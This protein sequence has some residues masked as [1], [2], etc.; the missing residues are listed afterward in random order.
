MTRV[1][2]VGNATLDVVNRVERYPVED[3]EVRAL[4]HTQR[5]GGNA[6]NTAIVLARL[7]ASSHWVGNLADPA[8][9]MER[10]FERLGV[11]ISRA[12]RIAGAR[13]PTSY[14]LV[15]A[16]TGSRSIVHYRDMPEYRADD[17]VQLDLDGFDWVHFEGRAVDQLGRMLS[18]A[19]STQGLP[20]S[21]E[22]E[23]PRPGIEALFGQADLLLFSRDYAEARGFDEA[24][25]LLA[26]LP[27]GR[28]ASC[29]WGDAGAWSIDADGR[30]GH[31]PAP[32]L[33]TVVDTLGAGDVFNAALIHALASRVP[34]ERALEGAVETASAKCLHE[35]L[36]VNL[37]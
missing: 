17:F 2:C 13:P 3:S 8:V 27:R 28:R 16:A 6:A 33:A 20:I 35:G 4:A 21:L 18:R 14:V 15:S 26:S 25:A 19:R 10:D 1:M 29:T 12:A 23:K 24:P 9:D 37:T 32:R 36:T 22:V 7:G 5:L 34:F 11:D 31:V 30:Q